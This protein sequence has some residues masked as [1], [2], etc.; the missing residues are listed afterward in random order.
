M[1]KMEEVLHD[2]IESEEAKKVMKEGGEG[3]CKRV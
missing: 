2:G 1:L 3:R